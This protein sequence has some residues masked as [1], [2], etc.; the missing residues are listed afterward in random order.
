[1]IILRFN[2][3]YFCWELKKL[4]RESGI[5]PTSSPAVVWLDSVGA[6]VTAG[7]TGNDG[8]WPLWD[9]SVDMVV[10]AIR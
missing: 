3:F 2:M 1:M 10:K 5:K 9:S 6:G 8:G 4:F 7:I